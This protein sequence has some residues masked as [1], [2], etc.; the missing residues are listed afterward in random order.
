[1]IGT[2]TGY[3]DARIE[4]QLAEIRAALTEVVEDE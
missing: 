2:K 1:V 4:T 3:L